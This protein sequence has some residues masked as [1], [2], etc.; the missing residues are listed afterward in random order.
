MNGTEI[1]AAARMA[2]A[3][4]IE[5]SPAILTGLGCVGMVTTV[6]FAVKA[7]PRAIELI[8]DKAEEID[9][10]R[11]IYLDEAVEK[12]GV[13][14][15]V[16]ASWELYIPAVAMGTISIACL[17]GAQ[18]INATR[19]AALAGLY[20]VAE[21]TLTD[22]QAKV[23]EK[24]GEKKEGEIRE[25]VAKEQV[26]GTESSLENVVFDG[27]GKHLVY[28]TLSG[29]YFRSDANEIQAAINQCNKQMIDEIFLDL[30]EYY[31]ALGLNQVQIGNDL[32]W[33]SDRLID[34][35]FAATVA[36]NGEPCIVLDYNTLP[37]GDFR[38]YC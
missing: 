28:D 12:I 37:R 19:N 35:N 9:D 36:P 22:Y 18:R 33:N 38:R 11:P 32:G 30:N 17:I 24:I 8:Q 2:Q 15:A 7:T 4:I 14:E 26:K 1:K 10:E 3:R 25:E 16:K 27:T 6:I 34:V 5:N 31:I 21:K 20:S 13:K 23:V 29:R